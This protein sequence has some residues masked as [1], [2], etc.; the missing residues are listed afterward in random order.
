[1]LFGGAIPILPGKTDRV[2]QFSAE[3]SSHVAEYEALNEKY[4]VRANAIWIS[5]SRDGRDMYVNVYEV[6]PGSTPMSERVWNPEGSAYDR[7]WVEWVT[8]VLGVDMTKER[9]FASPPERIFEWRADEPS[10]I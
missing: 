4:G 2:R 8:D 10:G 3:L 7:W 9:T 1:M 5:H 6:A